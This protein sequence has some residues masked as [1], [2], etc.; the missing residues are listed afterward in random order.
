M[1]RR[2]ASKPTKRMIRVFIAS[3]GDLAV[4]RRA[5]K[6]VIDELN[7][8]FGDGAGV[9]FEALAVMTRR[10]QGLINQEIDRREIVTRVGWH[11]RPAT[12]I[13]ALE[14]RTRVANAWSC[15]V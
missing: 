10:S 9:T 6:D 3:P 1:A 14:C 13:S 12:S 5:F 11:C 15:L 4:E 8:G 2:A 7:D